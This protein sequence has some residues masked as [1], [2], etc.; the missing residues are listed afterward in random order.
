MK[1]ILLK[2]I[3]MILWVGTAI[4][5]GYEIFLT[6]YIATQLYFLVQNSREVPLTVLARLSATGVGNI[7]AFGMAIIAIVIV[8]GGFDYHWRHGGEKKSFRLLG[9]TLIFQ[10]VFIIL[11]QI[12]SS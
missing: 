7:A 5:A 3:T 6:R 9:L 2:A 8:V 4:L 10:S 12:L 11:D 1:P